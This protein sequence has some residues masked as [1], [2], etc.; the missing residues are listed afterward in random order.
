MTRASPSTT[1]KFFSSLRAV[2]W[3]F[4]GL[5]GRRADAAERV[6]KGGMVSVI[7][8]ALVLVLVFVVTLIGIAKLAAGT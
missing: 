6:E 2:L 4:I 5:G 3:G 1:S 7:V 8:V